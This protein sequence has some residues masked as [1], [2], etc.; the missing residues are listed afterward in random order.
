MKWSD[1]VRLRTDVPAMVPPG[2][3]PWGPAGAQTQVARGGFRPVQRPAPVVP[4][5]TEPVA[6]ASSVASGGSAVLASIGRR[7]VAT[8]VDWVLVA[9]VVFVAAPV[10]ISDFQHRYWGAI[11]AWSEATTAAGGQSVPMS[12]DLV[13]VGELLMYVLIGATL[14]YNALALGV[15]SRTLGQRLLGIAVAPVD[16]PAAKVGWNRGIARALAWTLLSQGGG[17][18]LIVNAFSGSMALWHPKRQT[19][20]DL[21]ARTQVVRR[22]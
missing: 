5:V 16:K 19:V 13:H 2:V 15:W 14:L 6:V 20:P 12:D 17:L 9:V 10:F 8:A 11:W 1:Q 4:Q 22:R 18:L 3:N 21:L 7:F